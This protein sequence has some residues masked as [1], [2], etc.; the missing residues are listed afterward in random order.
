MKN[1]N[2]KESRAD[3]I[4]KHLCSQQGRIDAEIQGHLLPR[5]NNLLKVNDMELIKE[6]LF[7]LVAGLED[8]AEINIPQGE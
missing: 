8:L 7:L 5:V 6:Q 3:R 4:L 2:I 1:Q